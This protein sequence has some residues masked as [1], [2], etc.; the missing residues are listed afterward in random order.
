M[1]IHITASL[2]GRG[3]DTILR[4]C[5][6][7]TIRAIEFG[8]TGSTSYAE[9]DDEFSLVRIHFKDGGTLD[10]IQEFEQDVRNE[11]PLNLEYIE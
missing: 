5:V 7:R 1:S 11:N 8:R 6:G 3:T 9:K 2:I 4:E 10:I